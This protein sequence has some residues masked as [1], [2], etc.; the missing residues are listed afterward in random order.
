M[1]SII[2]GLTLVSEWLACLA[3][4]LSIAFPGQRLWPPRHRGTWSQ[5]AMVALFHLSGAGVIVSGVLEWSSLAIPW[6]VRLLVGAPAWLAGNLLA[7]W[8]VLA[9]GLP[10]TTGNPTELERLGPYRFSRHPQYTGLLLALPGWAI[11]T[12]SAYTLI[13]AIS[14]LPA[15]LLAACAEEIWLREKF[16]AAY[17]DYQRA[18]PLLLGLGR[19][20]GS[21]DAA[22]GDESIYPGAG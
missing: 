10:G 19:H 3:V 13:T 4:L 2:F 12:A 20:P 18:V 22:P 8:G 7:L 15:L 1:V 9:L 21:K 17:Y 16:G 14:A 5:Y 6:W 11:L